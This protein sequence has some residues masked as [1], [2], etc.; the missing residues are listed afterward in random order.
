MKKI[1]FMLIPMLITMEICYSQNNQI[2]LTAQTDSTQQLMT[3]QEV[4]KDAREG[5]DFINNEELIQRINANPKLIL[6]DVRGKDEYDAGHLKGATWLDRGVV[7]FT[8]ARTL[9]DPNAEIIVYCL[10]GNRS[11]L[12]VKT[13]KRMGYKNVKSHIGLEYWINAGLPIYNFLGEIKTL[14]LREL[15]AA[16]NPVEF[17]LDKK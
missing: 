15:N 1:T 16:T 14:K 6:I 8:L 13:L 3:I 9:R 17:Y 10:K 7:E 11:A 5:V 2:N 4:I 12:V